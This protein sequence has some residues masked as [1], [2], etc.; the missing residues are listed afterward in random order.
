MCIRDSSTVYPIQT[1]ESACHVYHGSGQAIGSTA[2][3]L[4]FTSTMFD[5]GDC[6]SGSEY[7]APQSGI[8]AFNVTYLVYPHANGVTTMSWQRY[9]GGG[10]SAYGAAIQNGAS[11]QNHT[12]HSYPTLIPLAKGEKVRA[13]C[14]IGGGSG[15]PT[16]YGGQNAFTAHKV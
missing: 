7:T 5:V 15:S 11:G 3:A 10:W 13:M 9:S 2:V 6:F 4:S 8:Y 12:Q 14:A 1:R 16:V